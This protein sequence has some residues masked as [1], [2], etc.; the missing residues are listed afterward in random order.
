APR[1]LDVER[2]AVDRDAHRAALVDG[3]QRDHEARAGVAA[4]RS[5]EA[6]APALLLRLAPE[7]A[8][9]EVAEAAVAAPTAE[10][11][12]VVEAGPAAVAAESARGRVDVV[13]G[14]V[15]TRAQLVVGR[16]ALR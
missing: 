4:R 15:A 9:E 8:F 11:L 10:H 16:A 6:G 1:H 12:F 2:A 13:A 7:Q 5:S 3:F 14:T